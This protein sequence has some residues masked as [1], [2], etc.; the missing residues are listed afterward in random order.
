MFVH[1]FL[2]LMRKNVISLRRVSRVRVNV[3]RRVHYCWV[4]T[5][6]SRDDVLALIMNRSAN[7]DVRI[8]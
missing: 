4:S 5:S 2:V 3:V 6:R 7:M 1:G 8:D